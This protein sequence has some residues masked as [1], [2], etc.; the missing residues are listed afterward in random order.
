[1]SN[2]YFTILGLPDSATL[3]EIKKA[4]RTKAKTLHPDLNKAADAKEQ[5]I[6]LNEAYEYL[7]NLKTGKIF[8]NSKKRYARRKANTTHTT[9]TSSKEWEKEE[10]IKAR[11]RA[12]E[13]AKMKFHEYTK[14]DA[15]KT[16]AAFKNVESL[17]YRLISIVAILFMCYYLAKVAGKEAAI[18]IALVATAGF[19]FWNKRTYRNLAKE[20]KNFRNSVGKVKNSLKPWIFLG[21]TFNFICIFTIVLNTLWSYNYIIL[22]YMVLICLK[23]FFTGSVEKPMNLKLAFRLTTLVPG[24]INLFFIINYIGSSKPISES[25][26]YDY[27]VTI[28]DEKNTEYSLTLMLKENAYNEHYWL[29]LFPSFTKAYDYETIEFEFEEGLFGLRVLKDYTFHEKYTRE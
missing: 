12:E 13:Y 3:A 18:A 5:F 29:R 23:V 1:M 24:L 28:S 10:R 8:G 26:S 2:K 15:Y 25:Y 21:T 11:K 6:E 17:T 4:Y 22:I 19:G 9:Y 27:E 7:E 20:L 14:T 16:A